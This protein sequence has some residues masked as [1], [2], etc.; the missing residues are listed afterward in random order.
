MAVRQI[1]EEFLNRLVALRSAEEENAVKTAMDQEFAPFSAKIMEE[2]TLKIAAK[3]REKDEAIAM[4]C[5]EYE[6]SVAK[7]SKDA[8]DIV[9]ATKISIES[10]ARA[11][12]TR[13]LDRFILEV[14]KAAD[15]NKI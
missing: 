7:I 6:A 3:T 13:T 15:N 12:A 4:I 1:T 8:E 14:S 5:K 11:S 10:R 2:K 9:A